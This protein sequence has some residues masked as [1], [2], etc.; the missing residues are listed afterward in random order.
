MLEILNGIIGAGS[1]LFFTA[2][3]LTSYFEQETRAF[4]ISLGLACTTALLWIVI[5]PATGLWINS[6]SILGLVGIGIISL[7]RFF[8]GNPAPRQLAAAT[9]YD[10]R[11]TMFARNNIQHYPELMDTYYEMR[12]EY[13]STDKQIHNKPEFG[14]PRQIFHDDYAAPLYDAAFGYLAQT[15]PLSD[16]TPHPEKKEVNPERFAKSLA[17]MI[18]F[19]GGCDTGIIPHDHASL[20]QP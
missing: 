3:A 17:E 18:R 6:L 8:P 4:R 15:I 2:L 7:I 16:G 13:L 10:E 12:P 19:Y 9:Q 11:D 14:D 20:L 1:A 5:L